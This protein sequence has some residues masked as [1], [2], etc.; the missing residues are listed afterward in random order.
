M[1]DP[2]FTYFTAGA[3]GPMSKERAERKDAAFFEYLKR[4][5]EAAKPTDEERRLAHKYFPHDDAECLLNAIEAERR[6][7]G[8]I[9]RGARYRSGREYVLWCLAGEWHSGKDIFKGRRPLYVP[10]A[11][12]ATGSELALICALMAL[13]IFVLFV[14]S[15]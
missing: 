9:K 3:A 15:S 10:P 1:D 14:L 7:P 4:R 11:R 8:V 2:V 12:Q 5:D 13:A 6:W